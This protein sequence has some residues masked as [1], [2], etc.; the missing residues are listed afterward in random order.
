MT[1]TLVKLTSICIFSIISFDP[2]MQKFTSGCFHVS[3]QAKDLFA[4]ITKFAI[5]TRVNKPTN[6]NMIPNFDILF[7]N[8]L[9]LK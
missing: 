9:N 1:T 2:A 6:S 5:Q 7:T 4:I 3:I 8:I